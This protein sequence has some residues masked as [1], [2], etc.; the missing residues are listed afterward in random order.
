MAAQKSAATGIETSDGAVLHNHAS[1][2]NTPGAL[3]WWGEVA[4]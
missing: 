1:N 2:Y 3:K 4:P